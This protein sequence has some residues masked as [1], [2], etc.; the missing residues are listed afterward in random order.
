M[1]NSFFQFKQFTIQQD[2]CA[3]KVTTDGC[4]FGAWCAREIRRMQKKIEYVLDIG[5]GTGLLSLMIAQQC[6]AKIDAIEL[7]KEAYEQA[8]QN[9]AT[10]PWHKNLFVIQG[11]AKYMAIALAK[12]YDVIVSNP[13]FYENELEPG[14][15]KK[16]IAH[17]SGGLLLDD[18]LTIIN[19]AIAPEGQFYL[20]LPFKRNN[21]IESLL[22]KRD[23]TISRKVLVRQS[24][25]HDFFRI[26]LSARIGNTG[27]GDPITEELS[28]RDEQQN[29]TPEFA[30][31]LKD[32]YLYL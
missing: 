24:T 10:S 32:Y 4:L 21:E 20:L 23:L 27:K 2:R 1:S 3:M 28:I 5:A 26:M 14:N 18:L 7:D 6:S 19:D 9:M 17:H 12:N 15:T 16:N 11:D 30:Q 22:K 8:K 29:Y 31:L 25:K 13:P